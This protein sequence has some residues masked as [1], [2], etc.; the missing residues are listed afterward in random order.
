M[1]G[2]R[3]KYLNVPP[4]RTTKGTH[5]SVRPRLLTQPVHCVVTVIGVAAGDCEDAFGSEL[6]ACF[7]NGD[8]IA[9]AGEKLHSHIH[10][11]SPPG[12]I[13]VGSPNEDYRIPILRA[14]DRN[15]EVDG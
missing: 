10:I 14:A 4:V 3:E 9:V 12:K 5:A 6:A 2:L 15:V 1:L 13:S 11:V 7:L 8:H